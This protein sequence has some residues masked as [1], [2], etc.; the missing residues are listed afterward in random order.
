MDWKIFPPKEDVVERFAVGI[1]VTGAGRTVIV[2][3][4]VL[5]YTGFDGPKISMA[6]LATLAASAV[7]GL[8]GFLFGVPK[9]PSDR[10]E[11]QRSGFFYRPNTNLEQVS[12]WLTKIMVVSVSSRP[13]RSAALSTRWGQESGQRLAIYRG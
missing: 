13:G 12:D 7:G 2:V 8:T 11:Q 6:M 3:G 10:D 5:L 4:G 1:F 9:G